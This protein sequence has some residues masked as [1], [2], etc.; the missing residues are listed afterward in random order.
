M[1]NLQMILLADKFPSEIRAVLN[2]AL[3]AF[4]QQL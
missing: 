4:N 2:A 3:S 1:D